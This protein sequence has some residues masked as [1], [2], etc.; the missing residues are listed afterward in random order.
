MFLVLPLPNVMQPLDRR[1]IYS[2]VHLEIDDAL[3]R[4]QVVLS[5]KEYFAKR[6]KKEKY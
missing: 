6:K 5:Y 3:Y 2:L 1:S 4:A